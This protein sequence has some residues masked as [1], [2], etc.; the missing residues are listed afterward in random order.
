MIIR[1]CLVPTLTTLG[2]GAICWW[3]WVK[4]T[5]TDGIPF[6]RAGAAGTVLLV[7]V[8]LWRLSNILASDRQALI[9]G[10]EERMTRM[11][12]RPAISGPAARSLD[13]RVSNLHNR[14]ERAMFALL[15]FDLAV[16]TIIWGFGDLIKLHHES[17]IGLLSTLAKLGGA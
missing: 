6:A 4:S 9:K 5:S 8:T 1:Y 14:F 3:G 7:V 13:E 16:A 11:G 2:L 17:L 12:V 15:A 10:F